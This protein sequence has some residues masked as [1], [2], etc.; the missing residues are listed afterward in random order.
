MPGKAE[1]DDF[2]SVDEVVVAPRG[3][4]AVIDPDLVATLGKLREGQ[5][6]VVKRFGPITEK[7]KRPAV[8]QK[9]RSHWRAA[10]R[11][12]EPRI[13]YHPT[14]GFPQVR[15]KVASE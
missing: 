13:D 3:R 1:Q 11:T 6:V 12:D 14:T 10:G 7:A 5:A 8:S 15:V 2:V 9:I 4:K